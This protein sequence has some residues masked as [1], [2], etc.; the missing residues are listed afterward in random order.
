[1]LSRYKWSALA[2]ACSVMVAQSANGQVRRQPARAIPNQPVQPTQANPQAQAAPRVQTENHDAFFA[3]W[4]T[5]DN[6][7]EIELANLALQKTTSSDVKQFAEKMIADHQKMNEQLARFTGNQVP[8]NATAQR[9]TQPD[10]QAPQQAQANSGQRRFQVDQAEPNRRTVARVTD[11]GEIPGQPRQQGTMLSLKQELA[12]QCLA[13]ARQ[14]LD[15]KSGREFDNCYMHMQIGAHAYV[16]DAMQVFQRHASSELK[17]ALAAG[18][19]T[20]QAHLQMAKKIVENH[21]QGADR[22]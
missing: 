18:E 19:Q 21:D 13:S 10:G 5:L 12:D 4:L 8:G 9:A 6:Q 2:I 11:Q 1:M 20:A 22:Q 3:E 7:N 15:R 17:Q 16:V 14:E